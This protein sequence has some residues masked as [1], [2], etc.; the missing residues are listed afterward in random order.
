MLPK[1]VRDMLLFN[2]QDIQMSNQS[3][4]DGQRLDAMFGGAGRY[5]SECYEKVC[6]RSL[7]AHNRITEILNLA[8]NN[9]HQEEVRNYLAELEYEPPLGLS[10]Q[11][12]CYLQD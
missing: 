9:G 11:A 6:S 2:V 4:R 7:A 10:E 5:E 1:I 3:V 12:Q 8:Q